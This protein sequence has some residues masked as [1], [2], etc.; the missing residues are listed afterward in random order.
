MCAVQTYSIL[1]LYLFP[2]GS[3]SSG[4]SD[5]RWQPTGTPNRYKIKGANRWHAESNIRCC[6]PPKAKS[7]LV[8]ESEELECCVPQKGSFTGNPKWRKAIIYIYSRK[9][10]RTR[11]PLQGRSSG[12]NLMGTRED[13]DGGGRQT[14]RAPAM[15]TS[16]GIAGR[17]PLLL[18]CT[19]E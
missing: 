17:R 13:V 2:S 9:A 14:V 12:G 3:S 19:Q 8:E 5:V 18:S 4:L 6:V 1:L 16:H 7:L 10:S 11:C 15:A